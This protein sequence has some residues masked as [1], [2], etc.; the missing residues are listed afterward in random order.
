MLMTKQNLSKC[1]AAP[2]L[3]TCALKD[4]M[5]EVGGRGEGGE[6]RERGR[7]AG[8]CQC[9]SVCNSNMKKKIFLTMYVLQTVFR[10]NIFIVLYVWKLFLLDGNSS[11]P[12]NFPFPLSI[13][14]KS[15]MS[16]RLSDCDNLIREPREI[17]F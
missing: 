15:E 17:V 5:P 7:G 2:I 14:L 6:G 10:Q 1:V 4:V 11:P 12:S 13:F 8:W 3:A 9:L 16:I